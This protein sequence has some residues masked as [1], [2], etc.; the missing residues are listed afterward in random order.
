MDDQV[1]ETV[2]ESNESAQAVGFVTSTEGATIVVISADGSIRELNPGDPLHEGDVLQVTDGAHVVLTFADGSVRE[3]SSGESFQLSQGNF[4]QLALSDSEE[5]NPEFEDLLASLEA[6]E[7][8][9]EDQEATAAGE[10]GPAGAASASGGGQLFSL[11]GSAVTPTA[12][13]DPDYT[14]PPLPDPTA[15]IDV[16]PDNTPVLSVS[17]EVE[18]DVETPPG[19]NPPTDPNP[20]YPVIVSG[21]AASILE[22]TNGEEGREVTFLL[23]L[24]EPFDQDVDVTYKLS[25]KVADNPAD[26]P[27]DWLSGDLINTVTIPAGE[28]TFPVTV[29]IV[30]DHLDEDNEKFEIVILEATN[31]TINPDADTATVTIFDDDTTPVAQAD[32]NFVDLDAEEIYEDQELQPYRGVDFTAFP[33]VTGTDGAYGEDLPASTSGNVLENIDHTYDPTPG[34]DGDEEVFADAQD[35]DEDG[36]IV[37]VTGVVAHGED[38][39]LGGGDDT[40]GTVGDPLEGKYGTL[41]LQ[42]DGEYI[43]V[44]DGEATDGLSSDQKVLDS[45]TYTVTD[46]YNQ[47][48]TATLTI[49][50][51]GGNQAPEAVSDTNWAQEDVSDASGNVLVTAA[52]N[53]APDA[54]SRGDVVDT[55]VDGD[56]LTVT[57]IADADEDLAVAAS[58]T[59]ADGTVV[60]GAYGALTIGADGSYSYIL[61]DA[62]IQAMDDTETADDVFTYTVSDGNTT[63][64]TTLTI[65]VFGSNDAPVAV[66][67]T[68]WAQ[69]DGA[70]ASGNVLQDLNHAGAPSGAF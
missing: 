32:T 39:A 42:D 52:H 3:L 23:S 64:T 25:P 20:S 16:N 37:V 35:T 47:P 28:T 21:N 26:N 15:D 57:N 38:G 29:T 24:S 48:Q 36:D 68:N 30:Q 1:K 22:G 56:A 55:D 60:T 11:L 34:E 6:G 69:E 9:S 19:E 13:I 51:F 8:I 50:I 43:Y 33:S 63:N 44:V 2:V 58:T 59:S 65:T 62:A 27:E 67:D 10:S 70:D 61:D 5:E 12:G 7:D 54:G 49:T 17:V 14:P 40:V 31:A 4:T 53:G 45:F 66:A 18:I 41:T 46:T